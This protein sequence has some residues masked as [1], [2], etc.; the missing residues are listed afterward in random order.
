ML[1]KL[2]SLLLSP[3][4]IWQGMQVR[5]TLPKLPE[6]SGDRTGQTGPEPRCKLLIVGDSSAAGV[7]AETQEEALL[8]NLVRELSSERG[9]E[10]QL[11]AKTGMRTTGVLKRI[12]QLESDSYDVVVSVLGVNDVIAGYSVDKWRRL[13]SELMKTVAR[14]F[15]DPAIV[16][17]PL[18]PMGDF[19]ALPQP[20]RWF[21]GRRAEAFDAELRS[22]ANDYGAHYLSLDLDA[23]ASMMASDGF[24]PGPQIYEKW[25]KAMAEEI[26]AYR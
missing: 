18:P 24:H 9:V 25:A 17:S 8:G 23:D 26:L 4:L 19:P 20:L 14:R 7:G 10:W 5:K 3:I 1:D 15:D 13:Q 6:A 21:L 16:V 22:C 11:I 2:I 12:N